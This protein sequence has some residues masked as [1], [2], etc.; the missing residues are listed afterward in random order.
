MQH[1]EQCRRRLHGAVDGAREDG[2]ALDAE[3]FQRRG[4][5]AH[6]L[7]EQLCDDQRPVLQCCGG[8]EGGEAGDVGEHQKAAL[9]G[10]H[11]WASAG[12][13]KVRSI[14]AVPIAIRA[15]MSP[16]IASGSRSAIHTRRQA[17]VPAANT[18]IEAL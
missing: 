4:D 7:L 8:D 6:H 17:C 18:C 15:R 9:G 2:V 5:V 10:A 16:T 13:A 11:A 12:A 14:A 1:I 3:H